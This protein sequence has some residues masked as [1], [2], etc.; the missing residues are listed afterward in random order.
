MCLRSEMS[1]AALRRAPPRR[2]HRAAVMIRALAKRENARKPRPPSVLSICRESRAGSTAAGFRRRSQTDVI[3]N[4][5]RI[6]SAIPPPGRLQSLRLT[7]SFTRPATGSLGAVVER[8]RRRP[9]G[10]GVRW[11]SCAGDVS[12]RLLDI[13]AKQFWSFV[14]YSSQTRSMLQ[15]DQQFPSVGSLKKGIVVNSDKSVDVYVRSSWSSSC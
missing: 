1:A 5:R 2:D 7:G 14:L 15:T 4:A 13:P 8:D 3:R 10:D 9:P 6:T 12:Y 11:H